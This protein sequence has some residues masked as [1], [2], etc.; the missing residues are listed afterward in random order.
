MAKYNPK[1]LAKLRKQ[2]LKEAKELKSLKAEEAKLEKEIAKIKS[3][4]SQKGLAAAEKKL[5]VAKDSRKEAE[6]DFALT[7]KNK[8]AQEQALTT[9]KAA[10]S[11]EVKLSNLRNKA[12]PHTK[13]ILKSDKER[14]S[15]SKRA[16]ALTKA[17][18]DITSQEYTTISSILDIEKSLLKY[19]DAKSLANYDEVEA[20]RM[21][22]AA[23][24]ELLVLSGEI[25]GLEK[26]LV[27]L[28][29]KKGKEAKLERE[30]IKKLIKEK[31]ESRDVGRDILADNIGLNEAISEQ[32]ATIKTN[33]ALFDK[34]LGTVDMTL[35]GLKG[36]K[37][38]L[39]QIVKA[40]KANPWILALAAVAAVVVVT[41]DLFDTQKRL[42]KEMN[43]TFSE[44]EGI[45]GQMK[46]AKFSTQGITEALMGVN[47]E[48]GM[49][50]FIEAT[51]NM[52]ILEGDAVQLSRTTAQIA[53]GFGTTSDKVATVA[54][55][56]SDVTGESMQSSLHMTA[57]VADLAKIEGAGADKVLGD[58]AEN[59]EQFAAYSM[60][61]G[62]N[63]MEAAVAARKLGSNL[64]VVTK[65]ADSLLDF[66]SSI[67][68]EMEASMLIGKQ[69]NYNKARE[70]ALE[71]DIAGAARDVVAQIGGK[72]ELQKMNVIQ[73]RA[74]ADSIGVSV[75]ELSRLAGGKLELSNKGQD[76]L[77]KD[78]AQM[79]LD[80]MGA[81]QDQMN[82]LK[83]ATIASTVAMGVLTLALGIA[84]AMAWK[85]GLIPGMKG[86]KGL[87]GPKVGKAAKSGLTKSGKFD[88]RTNKGKQ[89]AK[90]AAEKKAKQKVTQKAAKTAAIKGATKKA[91]TKGVAKGL[92]KAA[93][94]KIPFVGVLAGLA[95]GASRL[96]KGDISGA[97]MEVASGTAAIIPGLGTAASVALDAALIAKDVSNASADSAE[98]VTNMAD[99]VAVT[100]AE[101]TSTNPEV[102]RREALSKEWSEVN[103]SQQQSFIDAA[104][105]SNENLRAFL[106][107]LKIDLPVQIAKASGEWK[108]DLM[109]TL[110]WA[111]VLTKIADNTGRTVGEIQKIV[112]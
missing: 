15:V 90:E 28:Q 12:L 72:A 51:G 5:S 31:T 94:K 4:S 98:A 46:L 1:E 44:A 9:K 59:A 88:M 70:L 40:V 47:I 69:L 79:K 19:T 105:V 111:E 58:I 73:R 63:I 102:E 16:L 24:E 49:K 45:A 74:L 96:M 104:N 36:M 30:E 6:K 29:G 76:K 41:K 10:R 66:E 78:G 112:E 26:D 103:S 21:I 85:K 109:E 101:P 110:D 107:Q 95:F 67:E 43:M 20:K 77:A 106:E 33:N 13:A 54:K 82:M 42:S 61:G 75:D 108:K 52:S 99:E 97:L 83:S 64:G 50:S 62:K 53:T 92:G 38:T 14:W 27:D 32:A 84:A 68:K 81:L 55:Q 48:E 23:E 100:A 91:A 80:G 3:E 89:L 71:G 86:P 39:L 17:S 25:T 22:L 37:A 18:A 93:L 35:D 2:A 34:M 8:D 87:K 11:E 65:I 56:L 60:D 57:F 7:K